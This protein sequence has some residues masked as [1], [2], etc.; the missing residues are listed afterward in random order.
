MESYDIRWKR[1]Q[2]L[3][4]IQQCVRD[5]KPVIFT[6]ETYL[7]SNHTKNKSWSDNSEHGLKK[8]FG[9]GQRVIIVHAGGSTGFA[10]DVLL[11]FK[12]GKKLQFNKIFLQTSEK[13]M[14]IFFIKYIT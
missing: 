4:Q 8:P 6:D 5:K 10:N 9:K 2:Y 1:I 11:M 13:N 12:S 7:H 14:V 3:K